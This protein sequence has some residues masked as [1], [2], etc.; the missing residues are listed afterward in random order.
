M[1]VLDP[2]STRP[3]RLPFQHLPLLNL[4][5]LIAGL[6]AFGFQTK[7]SDSLIHFI[8]FIQAYIDCCC[9]LVSNFCPTLCNPMDCSMPVSLPPLVCSNSCS[10]SCWY[11]S[12]ISSSVPAFSSCPQSS[13]DIYW[14]CIYSNSILDIVPC[15]RICWPDRWIRK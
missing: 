14:V 13:T 12:A 3:C 5:G 8:G 1:W 10:L 15:L 7:W 9:C 2:T 11:Y 4:G 6:G